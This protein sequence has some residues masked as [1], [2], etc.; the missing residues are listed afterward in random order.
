MIKNI[1]FDIGN[2]LVGFDWQEYMKGFGFSREKENAIA[3]AMFGSPAWNEVDRGVLS[4]DEIEQLFIENAPQYREDIPR[5]FRGAAQCLT[6]RDY[7]IPWIQELKR[8]GFTIYYLSNFSKFVLDAVR[9]T[10]LDFLPYT[11]GGLFSYEVQQI[12]PDPAI[13]RSLLERYPELRPEE[14]VFFDDTPANIE[15]AAEL[16]FHA[17]HFRSQEQGRTAL[18]H[19]LEVQNLSF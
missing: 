2:V 19:L 6:R 11:D 3:K 14:S 7:A 15:A 5:V 1:I 12:K 16:G 8:Q 13:Y 17:I 18:V 10:V 4:I 9:D